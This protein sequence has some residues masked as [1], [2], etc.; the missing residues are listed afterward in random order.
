MGNGFNCFLRLL[1]LLTVPRTR[2]N[3]LLVAISG[4]GTISLNV[5]LNLE[6]SPAAKSNVSIPQGQY[7]QVFFLPF[8][9][10]MRW[11]MHATV[12]LVTACGT[13]GDKQRHTAL[14]SDLRWFQDLLGGAQVRWR[15]HPGTC[16]RGGKAR[17][18]E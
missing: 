16:G 8:I 10:S 15:A 18:R 2:T 13:C 11:C 5:N 7:K 6:L 12:Q 4:Q 9:Q 1:C 14:C 17:G 3:I